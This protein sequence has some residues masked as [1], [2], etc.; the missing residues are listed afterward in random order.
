MTVTKTPIYFCLE[1]AIYVVT[2]WHKMQELSKLKYLLTTQFKYLL[3]TLVV[4]YV[5]NNIENKESNMIY[6]WNVSVLLSSKKDILLFMR[7]YIDL[8]KVPKYNKQ[9]LF[10]SPKVENNFLTI[11]N[12]VDH[13]C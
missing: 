1:Q 12:H 2:L 11:D 5:E 7:Y 4:V 10:V 9:I 8:Y 13:L 6:E 3:T